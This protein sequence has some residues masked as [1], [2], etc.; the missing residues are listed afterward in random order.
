MTTTRGQ[1]CP[2]V[3]DDWVTHH[4]RRN[5]RET[6]KVGGKG[7]RF[8]FYGRTSTRRH[9]H[10][11][12]SAAWQRDAAE[13]TITGHGRITVEY[14]D[15]GCSRRR[16]WARRPRAAALLTALDDPNRG[17]DAIVIGEYE[18]AFSDDQFARLLPLL[19]HH[20]MQLWLPEAAD[21]FIWTIHSTEHS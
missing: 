12:T 6:P 13:H 8:A 21:A 5:T 17:F 7:I 16:P 20:G 10:R 11:T 2:D 18:R 19:E 4:R 14:F 1:H 3:L 9:Q 15:T